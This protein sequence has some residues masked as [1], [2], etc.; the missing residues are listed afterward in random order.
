M[1]VSTWGGEWVG[2]PRGR[3]TRG[4]NVMNDERERV[5]LTHTSVNP[6]L[7]SIS[8]TLLLGHVDVAAED[9]TSDS[10]RTSAFSVSTNFSSGVSTVL[11]SEN[12][13]PL[14]NAVVEETPKHSRHP[15]S[16]PSRDVSADSQPRRLQKA[17]ICLGGFR[18]RREVIAISQVTGTE[19]VR[20]GL[21]DFTTS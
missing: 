16:D 10:A 20:S 13:H 5:E 4:M 15:T 1:G 14:Q 21:S 12:L 9:E 3:K 8:T 7:P 19:R 6:T 17:D 18:T 2:A 11:E